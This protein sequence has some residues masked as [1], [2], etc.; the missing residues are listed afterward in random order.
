MKVIRKQY[1]TEDDALAKIPNLGNYIVASNG[2]LDRIEL[3]DPHYLKTKE[4]AISDAESQARDY[5]GTSYV[6]AEITFIVR[7]RTRIEIETTTQ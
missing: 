6:V 5:P 2:F 7:A 4:K 3:E 1:D